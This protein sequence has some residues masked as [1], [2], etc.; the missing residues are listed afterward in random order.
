MGRNP[1]SRMANGHQPDRDC[2]DVGIPG[3]QLVESLA[4][5]EFH[6]HLKDGCVIEGHFEQD[7]QCHFTDFDRRRLPVL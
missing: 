5:G 1:R 4:D 6:R 2:G 3:G 7:A